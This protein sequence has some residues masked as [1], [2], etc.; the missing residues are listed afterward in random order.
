MRVGTCSLWTNDSRTTLRVA[1]R[2]AWPA[3]L[4]RGVPLASFSPAACSRR[5]RHWHPSSAA[6]AAWLPVQFV[7]KAILDIPC[8]VPIRVGF[9]AAMWA[10]EQLAPFH[11][12]AT[13]SPVGEPLP[14]L[15]AS[16]A[17]LAGAMGIDLNRTHP[18]RKDLLGGVLVDLA[19]QLIGL[20]AVH[21]PRLAASFGLDLAQALKERH[22]GG[23]SGAHGG[24][25]AGDFVGVILIHAVHMAPELL[26]AALAFDR[27]ARLPLLLGDAPQMPIALL[28][29]ASIADKDGLD[30]L[31]MLPDRDH[32]EV[33]HIEIDRYRHQVRI[34]LAFP[35][36]LGRNLFGLRE[37]HF[38]RV[39]TQDQDGALVLPRL[40][41]ATLLQVAAAHHRGVDPLP[42]LAIIHLEPDKVALAFGLFQ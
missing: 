37:V 1:K 10:P 14:Q 40:F 17:K 29:E 42:R 23:I 13:S 6:D 12:D 41:A 36:P 21:A 22:G 26:V 5:G 2:P 35:H 16:R 20:L 25:A 8:A 19:A 9:I 39:R 28:I 3:S 4:W 33:F 27:L 38:G 7:K 32:R 11:L 30:D 24:N 34:E 15:S 31:L 18:L